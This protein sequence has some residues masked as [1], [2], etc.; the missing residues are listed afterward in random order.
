MVNEVICGDTITKMKEIEDNSVDL[1]VTDPPY[2]MDFQSHRRKEVYDKIKGDNNLDW[3]ETFMEESSRILKENSHAY[4]F[5]SFHKVDKFKLAIEKHFKIKNILIWKK[6][7]HGS[8]DLKGAYAPQYE[9]IIFCHK[10]RRLLNN[11]RQSD[12]LEFKKTG[13][14]LHP[15]EKPL[16]LI[17]YLIEKSS[18]ENEIVFDG[19]M[20][21]WTTALAS[22]ELNRNFI[23]FE[24]NEEYCEV[25]RRRLNYSPLA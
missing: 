9:M 22:K 21:S 12:I 7:N 1:I 3:L 15:T 14:K 11:G 17:K 20:G 25:G 6:N 16:D 13:N 19:F 4:F 18:N 8:G 2:G 24:I 10:G 5:C 23:G